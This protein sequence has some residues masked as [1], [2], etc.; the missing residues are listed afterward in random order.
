MMLS[1]SMRLLPAME[2][3]VCRQTITDDGQAD[4]TTSALLFGAKAFAL[5]PSCGQKADTKDRNYLRRAQ[6]FVD[7]RT[8]DDWRNDAERFAD[9]DPRERQTEPENYGPRTGEL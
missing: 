6:R 7:K 8:P 4:A 3:R 1:M 2:C 5:C 9:D